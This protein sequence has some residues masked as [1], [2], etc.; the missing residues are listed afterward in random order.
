[1]KALL[2]YLE[3]IPKTA[4]PV[5]AVLMVVLIAGIDHLS[6][7][8]ISV[9]LFYLSAVVFV[10]WFGK[11]S[12]AVV[13]CVFGSVMWMLADLAAGH[14]YS[15]PAIPVWNAI[16]IL[17]FFLISTFALSK[18]KELLLREQTLARIDFLTGVTNSLAFNEVAK[19]ELERSARFNRPL[20]IAYID[21]DNFKE[22]NDSLGHSQGDYIL[23]FVARVMK[24]NTRVIDVVSRLGGDEF[25]ILLPETNE[26]GAKTVIEKLRRHLLDA[27]KSNN[28]H[29]TFSIGVVTCYERRGVDELLKEAD[30]LMYSVKESGKDAIKYKIYVDPTI[31]A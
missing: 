29:I 30:K 2:K 8:E 31:D 16:M 22:V 18:I 6:G 21:I 3:T 7:Y 11:R 26:E 13:I 5:I 4:I 24:E 20:T 14:T 19:M 25:A 1:M 17:G 27:S 28:W 15:H 23:K 10:S 9:S 12:H